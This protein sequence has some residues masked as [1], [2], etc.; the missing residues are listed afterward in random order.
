VDG[1]PTLIRKD[2]FRSETLMREEKQKNYEK[3][4]I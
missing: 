1:V 4:E 2:M 3:Y